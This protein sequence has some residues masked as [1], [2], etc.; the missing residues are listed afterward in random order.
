MRFFPDSCI[1]PCSMFTLSSPIT[2]RP[3]VILISVVSM[4]PVYNSIVK[5]DAKKNPFNL[6]VVGLITQFT[7]EFTS[8]FPSYVECVIN[9]AC[10][11]VITSLALHNLLPGRWWSYAHT[12]TKLVVAVFCLWCVFC[13]VLSA[14]GASRLHC[15]TAVENVE[16]ADFESDQSSRCQS[17]V[18]SHAVQ[19]N[20]II[21]R[22]WMILEPPR[23]HNG[24]VSWRVGDQA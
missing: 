20:D 18:V 22:R 5:N 1:L 14:V 8:N 17:A 2:W 11:G 24:V 6:L 15:R 12:H 10:H 3:G 4:H 16:S 7:A 23:D 19:V 21:G 13:V 9:T